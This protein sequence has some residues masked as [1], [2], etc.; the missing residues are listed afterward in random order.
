MVLKDNT[1]GIGFIGLDGGPDA[2]LESSVLSI[3]HPEQLSADSC[4]ISIAINRLNEGYSL[5]DDLDLGSMCGG[6]GNWGL[7]MKNEESQ[8][9][10]HLV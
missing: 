10:I 1:V 7:P 8:K 4:V 2:T 3:G 6:F 9:T 5:R